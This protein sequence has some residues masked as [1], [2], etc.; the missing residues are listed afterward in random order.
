M[1][2]VL[3]SAQHYFEG[4]LEVRRR[5]AEVTHLV[6]IYD[7]PSHRRELEAILDRHSDEDTAE[8]RRAA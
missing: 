3:K 8:I 4:Q 7:S 1:K 2:N 6:S 5:A